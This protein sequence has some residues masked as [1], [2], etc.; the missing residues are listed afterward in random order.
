VPGQY[1]DITMEYFENTAN[2]V[3]QLYWTQPGGTKEIIPQ[4]QLYPAHTGLRAA[5]HASTNFT[6]LMFTRIDDAINFSWGASSPDPA[7]LPGVFCVRW[8]GKVRADAT[9]LYTFHTLTDDGVRLWVN[10]QPIINDWNVHAAIEN[11]GMIS[12]TNGQYYDLAMEYFVLK[13]YYTGNATAVLM[14]TPP[15][16]SKQVVP[17]TNLTPQQ[18]NNPPALGSI[19]NMTTSRGSLLA[20][21][22]SAADADVPAQS[23]AFSLDSGAPAGATINPFSGVFNWTPASNQAAG[24]YTVVVRVRDNGIP[25]MTDAQMVN[26]TV[27][28]D[29]AL[30]IA[31]SGSDAVLSWPAEVG[32][33]Q[34]YAATN[35]SP[36]VMW[37]PVTN[38]P[39]LS[40]GQ[41]FVPLPVSTDRTRFYRL[42][43]D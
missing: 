17:A 15:G 25:L 23:L 9:G 42:Q 5:Y 19:P 11:S 3:A 30:A 24:T 27:V 38:T 21:T 12:L 1:Y 28:P 10:G 13:G 22:A 29:A 34:L 31:I 37:T 32:A 2:A 39:L 20:F 26:I 7:L 4:T 43:R 40:N 6:R 16:G 33:F 35:L 8:T 14:W 41:F 18:N 36:P